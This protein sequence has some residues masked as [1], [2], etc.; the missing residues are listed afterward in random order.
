VTHEWFDKMNSDVTEAGVAFTAVGVVNRR[1][2]ERGKRS[3]L[4]V[5]PGQSHGVPDRRELNHRAQR[6]PVLAGERAGAMVSAEVLA[7]GSNRLANR[8]AAQSRCGRTDPVPETS[9]GWVAPLT[10]VP[11]P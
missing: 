2:G 5:G 9:G 6:L 4:G 3:C 11:T 1:S 7:S 8:R 10:A